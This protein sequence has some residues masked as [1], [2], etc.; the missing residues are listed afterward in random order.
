MKEAKYNFNLKKDKRKMDKDSTKFGQKRPIFVALV[1]EICAEQ[2]E[3]QRIRDD[4]DENEIECL[5]DGDGHVRL[6]R[7]SLNMKKRKSM[8]KQRPHSATATMSGAHRRSTSPGGAH[9]LGSQEAPA[10]LQVQGERARMLSA[11]TLGIADTAGA[12]RRQELVPIRSA[13]VLAR[14]ALDAE[15]SGQAHGRI[16]RTQK[17]LMQHLQNAQHIQESTGH[18]KGGA[19]D[20][21]GK[22]K[23]AAVAGTGA[24]GAAHSHAA[25]AVHKN[26][27]KTVALP[28]LSDFTTT[29][30]G[31]F[32]PPKD[33]N[34]PLEVKF[35]LPRTSRGLDVVHEDSA[36]HDSGGNNAELDPMKAVENLMF[37]L[38]RGKAEEA[39]P[40]T[41]LT[42]SQ[43]MLQK[44][45]GCHFLSGQSEGDMGNLRS[46]ALLREQASSKRSSFFSASAV[47]D[48][49]KISRA[50][51]QR[52]EIHRVRSICTSSMF[53]LFIPQIL[54]RLAVWRA[55]A[56]VVIAPHAS[57]TYLFLLLLYNTHSC[58]TRS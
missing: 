50:Q 9:L 3:M 1:E 13:E 29:Q 4:R 26:N 31:K 57:H 19:T 49:E 53:I 21:N 18:T 35:A 40:Q 39:D 58:V 32:K 54:H 7:V 47:R 20:G 45:K 27:N 2:E 36:S 6:S 56:S 46:F 23:S 24:G 38:A 41:E 5:H 28:A 10:M 55:L 8:Q 22:G 25:G 11:A 37:L 51:S 15:L 16:S 12:N 42:P 33:G 52:D 17:E 30:S 48:D 44:Q 34:A 43:M 14:G